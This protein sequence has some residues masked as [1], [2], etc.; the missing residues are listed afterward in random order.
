MV[1]GVWQSAWLFVFA[2]AG[3]VMGAVDPNEP[4]SE[5]NQSLGKC[6]FRFI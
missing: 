4:V 3:T 2:A 6:T 5:K 1:G